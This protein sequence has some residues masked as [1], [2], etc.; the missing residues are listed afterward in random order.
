[1]QSLWFW[2]LTIQAMVGLTALVWFLVQLVRGRISV[3]ALRN[4]HWPI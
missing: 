4:W 2:L 1:M 3:K